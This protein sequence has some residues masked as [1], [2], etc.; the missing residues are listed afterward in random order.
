[1]KN[2]NTIQKIIFDFEVVNN[3]PKENTK[4]KHYHR[5]LSIIKNNNSLKKELKLAFADLKLKKT[6]LNSQ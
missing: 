4:S 1:M 5:P 3:L 2:L 6:S